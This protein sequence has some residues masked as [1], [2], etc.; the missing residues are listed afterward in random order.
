VDD[1]DGE[2]GGHYFGEAGYFPLVFFSKTEVALLL[3]VKKT[4]ALRRQL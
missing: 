1:L 2:D 4:P 3:L